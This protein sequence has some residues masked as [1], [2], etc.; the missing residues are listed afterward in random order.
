MTL[1]TS[2]LLDNPPDGDKRREG[3]ETSRARVVPED[4]DGHEKPL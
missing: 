4:G 1:T 3:T 2:T